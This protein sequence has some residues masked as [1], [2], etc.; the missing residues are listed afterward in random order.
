MYRC[1]YGYNNLAT[2]RKEKVKLLAWKEKEEEISNTIAMLKNNRCNTF[3]PRVG[4]RGVVCLMSLWFEG[5]V[6]DVTLVRGQHC[7][8]GALLKAL[9]L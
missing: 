6:F 4:V 8:V 2:S 9:Y 5:N 1:Y 7:D 3:A